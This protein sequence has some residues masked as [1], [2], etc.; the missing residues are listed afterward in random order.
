LRPDGTF[1]RTNYSWDDELYQQ[2][3]IE[4]L[5]NLQPRVEMKDTIYLRK[6]ED[7]N[8]ILFIQTGIV[9]V[10][11]EFKNKQRYCIR[12][13]NRGIVGANQVCFHRKTLFFYKI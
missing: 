11:F 12:L 2:F 1:L 8:E 7:V 4:I 13:Q 6:N 10:G 5:T 9:I 3:M